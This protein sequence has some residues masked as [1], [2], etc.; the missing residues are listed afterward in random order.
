MIG[1]IGSKHTVFIPDMMPSLLD[2]LNDETPA[3]A[4]QAVKTGTDLFAKV[5]QELVIQGLFS[6]GGI[7]ESLKSSWEWMLKLKS[8]V[9]LMA[10]QP[11]SNEGVRMLAVKFVEKTVLMHTPDPNITSDPPNQATEDTGF[12]IAWLRGGHPLLNVGDLAMEASQSLGLLLE[13]LKSPKIRL[14]STSMI[15]VF[16]TS[17]SAIAQ[18]RPSFYGRIL[19]VLLSLDP[20]NTIIKVQIPGAFHALKSAIDACLKCTHSSA[21]PWRARLLEAQNIINQGD[22]IAANDSNAGRSAGDTSNRAESLPLTET[23]T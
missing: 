7:D 4:R 6:S 5:L 20:A 13:Q 23:R 8:A 11:T 1:E 21:E 17:L 2:L 3:V 9:S 19:P 10:F 16:V 22:S 15:I 18:R 14:L 12:N